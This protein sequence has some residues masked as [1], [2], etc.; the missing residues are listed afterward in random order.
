MG[1]SFRIAINLFLLLLPHSSILKVLE[2]HLFNMFEISS[3]MKTHGRTAIHVFT[4][5]AAAAKALRLSLGGTA[6]PLDNPPP[7]PCHWAA[8]LP[9]A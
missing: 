2:L 8:R 1:N 6:P 7:A 5:K 9:Y 4:L 3:T